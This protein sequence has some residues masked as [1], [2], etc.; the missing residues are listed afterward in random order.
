MLLNLMSICLTKRILSHCF[1][2]KVVLKAFHRVQKYRGITYLATSSS[3]KCIN[4]TVSFSSSYD[5]WGKNWRNTKHV[6][7]KDLINLLLTAKWIRNKVSQRVLKQKVV[8]L[9]FDWKTKW[10]YFTPNFRLIRLTIAKYNMN[11]YL[12]SWP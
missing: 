1:Q 11:Y 5:K 12:W 3:Y 2:I 9:T 6:N 10:S 4:T 8:Q 7:S